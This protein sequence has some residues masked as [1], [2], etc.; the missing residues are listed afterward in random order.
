M[1]SNFSLRSL[2]MYMTRLRSEWQADLKLTWAFGSKLEWIGH[3]FQLSGVH[4]RAGLLSPLCYCKIDSR[5][6]P[7]CLLQIHQFRSKI[8]EKKKKK[9]E[10]IKVWS[11]ASSLCLFGSFVCFSISAFLLYCSVSDFISICLW[12]FGYIYVWFF[13][14]FSIEFNS[15]LRSLPFIFNSCSIFSLS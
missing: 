5:Y 6:E 9:K 10:K 13:V 4:Y 1:L 14:L 12:L 2:S 7:K 3:Q 11:T 15:W 8:K